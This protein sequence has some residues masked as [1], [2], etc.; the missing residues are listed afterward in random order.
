MS[1][2]SYLRWRNKISSST[3]T[4]T[5]PEMVSSSL[6]Q[7]VLFQASDDIPTRARNMIMA[8]NFDNLPRATIIMQMVGL[9]SIYQDLDREKIEADNKSPIVV[10]SEELLFKS[11]LL[12]FVDV[13]DRL[14]MMVERLATHIPI[15]KSH[16]QR[17]VDDMR[18]ICAS[19]QNMKDVGR[20]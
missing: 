11:T 15:P 20:D 12:E 5:T 9:L 1:L 13:V 8:L 14:T 7:S 6:E 2:G 16:A 18:I 19:L 10:P 17:I 3:K 4:T